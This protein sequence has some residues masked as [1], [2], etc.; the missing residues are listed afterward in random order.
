MRVGLDIFQ[1]L[2]EGNPPAPG[3]LFFEYYL[4]YLAIA[5]VV[6]SVY[7]GV[8]TRIN[9]HL[10]HP[11]YYSHPW[12][13]LVFIVG[14]VSPVL[15][16]FVF[17]GVPSLLPFPTEIVL[18]AGSLVWVVIHSRRT[19]VVAAVFMPFFVSLWSSGLWIEAIGFHIIHNLFLV[20]II[21]IS[22]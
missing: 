7:V 3:E 10:D 13:Y 9:G 5:T 1:I 22:R 16:E 21:L 14:V 6:Y 17:R 12:P 15:E 8:Y 4:P 20:L 18:V 2:P 11:D 19:W